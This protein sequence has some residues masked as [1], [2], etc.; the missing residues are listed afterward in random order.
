MLSHSQSQACFVG[1]FL[2]LTGLLP[3]VHALCQPSS[4]V[5]SPTR[6]QE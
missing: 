3:N 1:F 2:A 6:A 4:R 5:G